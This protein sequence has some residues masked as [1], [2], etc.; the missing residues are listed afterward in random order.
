[1]GH[2]RFALGLGA[3]QPFGGFLSCFGGSVSALDDGG[4]SLLWGLDDEGSWIFF[5]Y[6]GL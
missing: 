4:E 2:L 6:R 3:S 1:M 5:G